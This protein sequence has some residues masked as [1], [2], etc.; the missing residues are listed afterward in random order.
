MSSAPSNARELMAVIMTVLSFKEDLQ[1]KAVQILTDNIS[2]AAYIMHLGGPSPGLSSMVANL[3]QI[4]YKYN[5]ELTARFLAGKDNQMADYLSRIHAQHE[6]KLHPAIFRELDFLWG[7]H[8]I[9]RF[10]S[11]HNN[12]LP[13]YNARFWDPWCIGVDALAQDD[14]HLHNNFV[15]CPFSL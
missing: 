2:T 7:K 6:W 13:L 11:M 15:N 4:C 3:W 1:D 14:W 8:S 12:L 5:I 9:D 10:A